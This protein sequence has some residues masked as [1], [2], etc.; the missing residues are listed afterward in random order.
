[1]GEVNDAHVKL[2]KLKGEFVSGLGA[3]VVDVG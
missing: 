3:A 2:V 1:V